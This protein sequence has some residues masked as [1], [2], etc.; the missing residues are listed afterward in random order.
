[1]V[2]PQL[3]RKVWPAVLNERKVATPRSLG[4]RTALVLLSAV[5]GCTGSPSSNPAQ[6]TAEDAPRGL[7]QFGV[8][9]RDSEIRVDI[10][11]FEQGVEVSGQCN[12][13]QLGGRP[14]DNEGSFMVPIE[15]GPLDAISCRLQVEGD[16]VRVAYEPT[17]AALRQVIADEGC[18]VLGAEEHWKCP[19]DASMLD[20]GG[21]LIMAPWFVTD[22]EAR[23]LIEGA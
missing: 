15:G 19:A 17:A 10:V 8:T 14:E 18:V 11:M 2:E 13:V 5:A 7:G 21:V 20:G 9:V 6:P 1:M 12:G 4:L 16:D 22:P 23:V 3:S